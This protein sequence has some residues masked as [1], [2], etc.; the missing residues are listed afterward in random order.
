LFQTFQTT[1]VY[2]IQTI[3]KEIRVKTG[4]WFKDEVDILF[5][6]YGFLVSFISVN[7]TAW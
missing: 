7:V 5:P 2:K 1:G 3:T 4:V 6:F